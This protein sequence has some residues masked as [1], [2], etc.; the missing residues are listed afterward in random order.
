MPTLVRA[1]Y[2]ILAMIVVM[3]A[4]AACGDASEPDYA[5][6]I[7]ENILTA[8]NDDNYDQ[9]SELFTAEMKD[10]MAEK[11]VREINSV[12][13]LE[14]GAYE[15]KEFWKAENTGLYTTV[16]YRARFT[17]EPE[18]VIVKVVFQKIEGKVYV[19]GLWLDSPKLRGA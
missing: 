9:Y 7:A 18:D 12:I 1:G 17:N 19:A 14:I 15:F 16:Y 3:V 2:G 8:I 11:V 5:S 10:K 6:D 13:K 4:L